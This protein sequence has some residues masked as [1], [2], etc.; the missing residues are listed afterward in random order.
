M[1]LHPTSLSPPRVLTVVAGIYITQSAIGGLTFQ[2]IPA[3]LRAE[4][5]GLD[6]IGLVSLLMLPWALKFLWA[7]ALER[8]RLPLGRHRR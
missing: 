6:V 1:T 2:G 4:G 3:V 8:L 5:A 7:P